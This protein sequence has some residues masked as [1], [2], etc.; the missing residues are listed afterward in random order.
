MKTQL[1]PNATWIEPPKP[2]VK[3]EPKP[4]KPK[5]RPEPNKTDQRFD[6]WAKR[7]NVDFSKIGLRK[8]K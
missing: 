5:V 2:K 3:R 7:N 8:L 6:D 4:K 1:A